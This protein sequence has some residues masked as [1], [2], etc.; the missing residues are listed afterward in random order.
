M[1]TEELLHIKK[2]SAFERLSRAQIELNNARDIYSKARK[3]E[4]DA[5]TDY[6]KVRDEWLAYVEKR[7]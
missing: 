4:A 5:E 1:N 2:V 3:N 6:K 7:L